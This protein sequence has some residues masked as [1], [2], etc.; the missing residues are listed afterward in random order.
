MNKLDNIEIQPIINSVYEA[1]KKLVDFQK[2][3]SKLNLKRK[4]DN[5]FVTDADLKSNEILEIQLKKT[6]IPIISEEKVIDKKE[7][8]YWIIDPLDG[9]HDY[10]KNSKYFSINVALIENNLPKIGI[11]YS[12]RLNQLFVNFLNKDVYS[13]INNKRSKLIAIKNSNKINM[14]RSMSDEDKIFKILKKN[15]K[16]YYEKDISSAIKFG[17]L[18]NNTFNTYLRN[19]GSSEWDIAAGHAI[20]LGIGGDIIDLNTK[21]TISYSKKK[22]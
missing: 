22:L 9:T 18:A 17:F 14:L 13:I 3:I 16:P 21:K 8:T 1:G 10:I 12:P 19:I 4:N 2:K 11:V 15:F 20:L 5:T 6:N 7:N